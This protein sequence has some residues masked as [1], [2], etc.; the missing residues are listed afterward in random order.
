MEPSK[1]FK[2][3]RR[4]KRKVL[5]LQEAAEV[6]RKYKI[7]FVEAKLVKKVEEAVAFAEKA[8]Y[9]VI[10]KIV[11]RDV[12]HKTDVGGILMNIKN[13]QELERAF[14]QIVN[15]VKKHLPRARIDGMLVYKMVEEGVEVIVGGKKDVRFDQVLMFGLG[16]IFTE[17]LKDV[18]FRVVPIDKRDA[19]EMIKEIKGYE[20]LKGYRG[21]KCDTDAL[22]EILQKTSK[23]L[24]ENREIKELDINPVIVLKKSAVAIDARIVIG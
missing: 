5:T 15:N 20:V 12:V 9:P 10:L 16:G 7:P 21:K 22:V 24:D 19:E 6:L 11:S 14:R 23:L 13:G 18:S 8:G 4:E 3:V 17:V 1:I 2:K